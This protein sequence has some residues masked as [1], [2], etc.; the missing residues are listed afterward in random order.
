MATLSREKTCA[1]CVS[2]FVFSRRDQLRCPGCQETFRLGKSRD[3]ARRRYLGDRDQ[4]NARRRE[5]HAADPD[6]RRNY[7]LQWMYGISEQDYDRMFQGQ[8]G[9]CA[10]CG[11]PESKG[12]GAGAG[13]LC[14]DHCHTTGVVRGLLCTL[15]N[16]AIG[17][18]R[19]DPAIL[20]NA[21]AY[22]E[23]GK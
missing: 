10:I 1:D 20:R 6:R 8:G 18:L 17:K 16:S 14:V 7:Q 23:A 19:D 21:I 12:R 15:C 5:A 22:L 11:H 3:R 9:L 2:P 13:R 4:I